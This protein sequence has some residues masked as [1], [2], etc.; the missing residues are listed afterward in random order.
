MNAMMEETKAD[1][2]IT[3]VSAKALGYRSFTTPYK[4]KKERPL[5]DALVSDLRNG[6]RDHVLVRANGGLE[7]WI[8]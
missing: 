3:P 5:M 4:Y 1:E 7:V 2:P 8:K 6:N